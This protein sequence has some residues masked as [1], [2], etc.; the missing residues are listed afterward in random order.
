MSLIPV[1]D[2][3]RRLRERRAKRVALQLPAGLKRQAFPLAKALRSAGFEVIVS[4]DPC[5][6]ACDL[7]LGAASLADVLVHVG[8]TP[9]EGREGVLYEIVGGDFDLGVLEAALPL[10]T[11]IRIG[12]VTTAQHAHLIDPMIETLARHGI[13][14]RV[15]PGG[16]RAPMRGQV[17]GCSFLAARIPDIDEILYVGT[18]LFHPTGVQLAIGARVVAL[19]PYTRAAVLVDAS[20][21]LRRRFALMEKAREAESYGVIVSTK[22]G[23]Q[24]F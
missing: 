7:A 3:V 2:L 16:T 10:L 17:L 6:G 4:G 8:H 21:M 1:A 15:A 9:V 20:R 18:G 11:S 12:L 5:Y 24:R 19:D 13:D 23:Q 22:T 14:A